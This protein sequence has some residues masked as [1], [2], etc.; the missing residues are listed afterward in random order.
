M[1]L[2]E[3]ENHATM[4]GVNGV[5]NYFCVL[6]SKVKAQHYKPAKITLNGIGWQSTSRLE[7]GPK[8][9]Q[10]TTKFNR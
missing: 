6:R 2:S 8:K 4:L 5:C 3:P 1:M 10:R 7:I 9:C